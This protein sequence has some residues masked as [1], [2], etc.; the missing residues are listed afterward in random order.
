MKNRV[1]IRGRGLG[2]FFDDA[3]GNDPS[4]SQ[5]GAQRPTTPA[6]TSASSPANQLA[7]KLASS[8]TRQPASE[9]AIYPASDQ[10]SEPASSRAS[11]VLNSERSKQGNAPTTRADGQRRRL[12]ELVFRDHPKDVG[13]RF[14]QDEIDAL[15]DMEY[16]LEVHRG[17][18][19]TRNDLV[20]LGLN[21]LIEDYRQHGEDSVLVEVL[22]EERS[23]GR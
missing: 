8:P 16:E 20:R 21:H 7:S 1:S 6:G 4:S 3:P 12:R 5:E 15:R 22:K 14:A 17:I 11:E 10:A 18:K 23:R 2:A 9:P 13:Y 19:V